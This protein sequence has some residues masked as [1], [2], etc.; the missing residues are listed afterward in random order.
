L[1]IDPGTLTG[2]AAIQQ[3]AAAGAFRTNRLDDGRYMMRP[4]RWAEALRKI[5]KIKISQRM[6]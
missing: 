1:Q 3:Q 6:G 2:I 4:A 5:S